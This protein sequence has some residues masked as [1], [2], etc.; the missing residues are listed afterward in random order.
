MKTAMNIIL[1]LSMLLSGCGDENPTIGPESTVKVAAEY[2]DHIFMSTLSS[3]ELVAATPEAKAGDWWGIKP[4]LQKL[5]NDLP[6][7]YFYVMPDGN[8]YS[9]TKDYTNLNLS[10][11]DYFKPLF[12]GHP[13]I[14]HPIYS[15]S[16]GK[17]SGL[18]AAPIMEDSK[19]VGAIGASVFLNDLHQ[20]LNKDFDLPSNYIWYVLDATGNTMLKNESDFIFLNA[21][22]VGSESLKEALETALKNESGVMSYVM[23]GKKTAYYQKLSHLDWWLM[24]AKVQGPAVDDAAQLTLSL[25]RFVPELQRRLDRIDASLV[26]TIKEVNPDYTSES[27]IRELLVVI[28]K[29]NQDVIESNFITLDGIL[30]YI[31]P[32]DYKNFQNADISMQDHVIA[33]RQ[34]KVPEFSSAF[35]AVEGFLSVDL[36]YPVYDSDKKLFGSVSVLIRPELLINP[37]LKESKVPEDYELWIMQT[38]GKIVFDQDADEIGKML[39]DDPAYAKFESLLDL[40]KKIAAKPEG[41]GSYVYFAPDSKEEVV[42]DVI[43][44]TIKLHERE[45]RVV[46]GYRPYKK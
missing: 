2:L 23:N 17:R 38:D 28:L 12:E 13:V 40:G 35:M 9:L 21:M 26:K 41:E 34:D 46:L 29:D 18:M 43:W 11:R 33:L 42:K 20:K 14:G 10:N 7:V 36:A 25:D 15:R 37:L 30:R 39:F 1:A 31:E 44:K 5:G 27:E 3:L 32:A 22:T 45:W 4:Y 8:Y 24:M 19:V 6:G 16:T